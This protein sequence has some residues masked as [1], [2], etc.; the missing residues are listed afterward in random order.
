MDLNKD[1]ES[2][3]EQ[4]GDWGFYLVLENGTSVPIGVY[5][6]YRD[7]AAH[8]NAAL[9]ATPKA[10]LWEGQRLY[11]PLEDDDE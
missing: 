7:G 6:S 5:S 10:V 11:K 3:C 4:T 9:R 2:P 1:V 8:A